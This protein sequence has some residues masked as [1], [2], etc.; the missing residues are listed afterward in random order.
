MSHYPVRRATTTIQKRQR[1]LKHLWNVIAGGPSRSQLLSALGNR[2]LRVTRRGVATIR[3]RALAMNPL[4]ELAMANEPVR[5][6]AKRLQIENLE[7]R[8]VLAF[9]SITVDGTA[10]NDSLVVIATG[11]DSGS[12]P[13]CG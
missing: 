10:G 6:A 3:N 8:R 9:T 11:S 7:E 4:A 5:N 13:A 2:F 1:F 12:R